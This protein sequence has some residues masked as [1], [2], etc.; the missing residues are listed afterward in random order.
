MYINKIAIDENFSSLV[1]TENLPS[2]KDIKKLNEASISKKEFL[3]LFDSQIT[4][5]HL[6]LQA[7]ELKSKNLSFYTIG[8]SGHEG[9]AG[10]GKV[11]SYH[12]PA[13]LHYRSCAFF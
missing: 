9:N 7:R 12:D 1:L 5:R 4:S 8:S 3:S 2:I 6:D 10:L 13:F 11:F